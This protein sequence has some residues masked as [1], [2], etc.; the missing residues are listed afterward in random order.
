MLL[1]LLL[2]EARAVDGGMKQ[3]LAFSGINT[4]TVLNIHN[5]SK[6]VEAFRR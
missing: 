3:E 6:L 5:L 1:A 4:K 2:S